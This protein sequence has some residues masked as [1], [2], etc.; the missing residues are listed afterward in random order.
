MFNF[1]CLC[2]FCCSPSTGWHGK[3]MNSLFFVCH[4]VLCI[5]CSFGLLKTFAEKQSQMEF[6][7]AL[8]FF[9]YNIAN[10]L[11]YWLIIYDSY[12]NHIDH[13]AFW[14][15]F[16]KID[17]EFFSQSNI[18]CRVYIMAFSS[19]LI[20]DWI[21]LVFSLIPETETNYGGRIMHF[22]LL[23]VTDQRAFFYLLYLKLIKFQLK[24]IKT[25]LMTLQTQTDVD[26]Q[27][28]KWIR[29]YYNY[30][31][32][33]SLHVNSL[34]GW[35]NLALILLNFY[36]SVTFLNFIYRQILGKFNNL[37]SGLFEIQSQI[38]LVY[39]LK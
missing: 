36:T 39:F 26:D 1:F 28:L 14:E 5:W 15:I 29:E 7:D 17:M 19:I 27:K 18:G 10:D 21:K 35:S 30:V 20:G 6:L 23:S 8:N 12:Q 11:T 3:L 25:E 2:G 9:L 33:M 4:V 22:L 37:R 32:Q 13:C 38:N 31:Y 24:N 16:K 34:F